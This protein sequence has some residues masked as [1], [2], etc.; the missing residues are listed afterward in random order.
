M[1]I[2]VI[3]LR[4]WNK[5]HL[6]HSCVCVSG[7]R[8]N[9]ILHNKRWTLNK[10]C[11][12]I[13]SVVCCLL[14]C[15]WNS[16]KSIYE[17]IKSDRMFLLICVSRSHHRN[18]TNWIIPICYKNIVRMGDSYSL[19]SLLRSAL[20]WIS[21]AHSNRCI[22]ANDREPHC[23]DRLMTNYGHLPADYAET[24]VG[25][26]CYALHMVGR[27]WP[28]TSVHNRIGISSMQSRRTD[29]NA[30]SRRITKMHGKFHEIQLPFPS[31]WS[32]P[33]V[34]TNCNF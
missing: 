30:N 4:T 10:L 5:L 32:A 8:C 29:E 27:S 16:N 28:K 23:T 19:S 9:N 21:I 11:Q 22:P 6:N 34:R 2:I 12:V 33:N 14:V 24:E 31:P 18:A 13:D 26:M 3:T 7:A 20:L 1:I 17:R 15:L 25:F